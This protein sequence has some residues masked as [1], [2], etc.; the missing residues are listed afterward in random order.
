MEI[1]AVISESTAS[2][3]KRSAFLFLQSKE[4]T[5]VKDDKLRST[6]IRSK[7]K[8]EAYLYLR[9]FSCSVKAT[10][11]IRKKCSTSFF[12]PV[13]LKMNHK[14]IRVFYSRKK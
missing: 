8:K 2:R 4:H 1:F 14:N 10:G 7:K 5:P 6:R 13:L 3:L 9:D 11:S 12:F